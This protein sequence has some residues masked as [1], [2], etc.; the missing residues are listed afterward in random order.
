MY[1]ENFIRV[2][3]N[4]ADE[5]FCKELIETFDKIVADPDLKS[6]IK[7]NSNQFD[8]GIFGRRDLAIF[9]E[10]PAFRQFSL[11]DRLL[12]LINNCLLEYLDEFN[13]LKGLN[14]TNRANLKIQKTEPLGGYHQWHYEANAGPDSW[15]RE[16]VW[17]VY[18]NDM[19]PNEAET[20]FFYQKCKIQ[21]T[22]GTVV[23][24]PAAMTHVHR[25]NTVYTKNKYIATGWWYK[26]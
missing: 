24:W 17:M 25:G 2:W 4:R 11:C 15:S 10:D 23:I 22:R 7:D 13:I 5:S 26:S 20:E 21:P 6:Y 18:L 14:L 1:E 19:P 9:L 12:A 8:Q 3:P 16:L